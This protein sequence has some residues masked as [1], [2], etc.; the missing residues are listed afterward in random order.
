MI[1]KLP[2]DKCTGCSVCY[3]ICPTNAIEMV[4][5]REG[6]FYPIIREDV[7]INCELCEKRCPVMR[8]ESIPNKHATDKPSCYAAQYK[9][10][11]VRF[12]S[13]SGGAFSAFANVIYRRGGYVGGAIRSEDGGV[14]HFISNDKKDLAKL[15]QSKYTQ[16]RT[17]GFFN[18]VKEL[19]KAGHEVLICGT[20]CQVAGLRLFLKKDYEKLYILDF[21]CNN[22]SSPRLWEETKL[23]FEKREKSKLVYTKFKDKELGWKRRVSRYDFKNGKTLY[24]S[25]DT[26][27]FYD[28]VYHTHVGARP[29]CY[30][31]PFKGYPRY[32][33]I[34]MADYWGIEVYHPELDDNTGTSALICS[35]QKGESLLAAARKFLNV[36]DSKLEWIQKHNASLVTTTKPSLFDRNAF[37]D[38]IE[39]GKPL[40]QVLEESLAS[41]KIATP[42][43][44]KSLRV[45]LG[46][47]KRA[48]KNRLSFLKKGLTFARYNPRAFA[49]FIKYN[50]FCQAVK[51][52]NGAGFFIA[53]HCAIQIE[54]G[55]ELRLDGSLELGAHRLRKGV[56]HSALLIEKDA[57]MHVKVFFQFL[58][59]ADVELFKGALME[60]DQGGANMNCTIICSTRISIGH[61]THMGRDV[62]VRDT[63][64]HIIALEG[65]KVQAPVI[66]ESHAWLCSGCSISAGTYVGVGSIIGGDAMASGRIPAHSL[67]V[68]NPG[69]VVMKNIAW[70]Y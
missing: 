59:G 7:C 26:G 63:N 60:L 4:V 27:N 18:R 36:A 15:R 44:A 32:A 24:E 53:P 34:T 10:Y 5:D 70:K 30:T 23:L 14:E 50:F 31:C 65:Y 1:D 25:I 12:D 20:P 56:R 13:T 19:L 58:A 9:S 51:R 6:F 35:T 62:S 69:K 67:V 68:G 2:R 16:S 47:W 42:P 64:A 29:A 17:V 40:D 46:R 37:F 61:G 21:I 38:E 33:D 52:Y 39:A 28:R 55:A 57:K 43:P 48:L 22:I 11:P 3:D 49:Q 45:T 66:I 54:K 8:K 41:I